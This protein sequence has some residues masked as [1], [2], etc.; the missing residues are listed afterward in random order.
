MQQEQQQTIAATA[1]TTSRRFIN[2]LK[3]EQKTDHWCREITKAC[4]EQLYDDKT[5]MCGPK[6]HHQLQRTAHEMPREVRIQWPTDPN[7]ESRPNAYPSQHKTGSHH[8]NTQTPGTWTQKMDSHILHIERPLF[9]ARHANICIPLSKHG[10]S[11]L[12]LPD[13]CFKVV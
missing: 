13:E 4:N 6:P 8:K 1:T 10:A 7:K 3:E 5:Q 2:K 9:L 12:P 11:P